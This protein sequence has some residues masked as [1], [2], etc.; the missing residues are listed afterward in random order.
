VDEISIERDGAVVRVTLNRPD[1]LNAQTP[2]MWRHLAARGAEM[3]DDSSIRAL[4]VSGAGRSFSAGIDITNFT[5]GATPDGGSAGGS[6]GGRAGGRDGAAVVGPDPVAGVRALQAGFEWLETAPFLTIARVQGHAF[7]AGMQLALACDVRVCSD[8]VQ[9][10]LL[11][12][13]WGLMPDLGG[14]VWLPRLIGPAAALEHMLRGD[15]WRAADVA[16]LGL[17]NRVVP[18]DELDAAVAEYVELACSRPPLAIRGAKQ[19]IREG[20]GRSTADGMEAAARAQVACVR[21]ADFGE[22]AAAFVEGRP[23]RFTGA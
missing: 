11:E 23:A 5:A 15:K 4:V 19:A 22:A 2:A 18:R 21:S 14:T 17:A 3:C 13:N 20:W 9:M 16:R 12:F 1:K 8:D 7:G 10:G 6:A